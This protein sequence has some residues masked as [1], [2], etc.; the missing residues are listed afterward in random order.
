MIG[1]YGNTHFELENLI[2]MTGFD[3]IQL[4]IWRAIAV[5]R[6]DV[7]QGILLVDDDIVSRKYMSV[8]PEFAMLDDAYKN[9]LSL[10]ETDPLKQTGTEIFK[11]YGY[12]AFSLFLKFAYGAHDPMCMYQ[13]W[14]LYPGWR[15]DSTKRKLTSIAPHFM[16][17]INWIDG[18][19]TAN[20]FTKIGRAYLLTIDSNGYSMEHRDPSL[21]PDMPRDHTAEFIHVR[22]NTNR[23]FYVYDQDADV[24]HYIQSR[25]AW[26]NP[27]DTHGG[28][29]VMEPSYAIRIDGIFSEE[30]KRK[31]GIAEGAQ[32]TAPVVSG[33]GGYKQAL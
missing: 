24:K 8:S 2:D 6:P 13:L 12:N 23:P 27:N 16:S 14:D 10:P 28:G 3:A 22:P 29:C 1:L 11:N 5:T 4:E 25:V 19:V 15:T 31:M 20:V 32:L 21:D 30:F 18:L 7:R 9:Y 26:F 33:T 17:L